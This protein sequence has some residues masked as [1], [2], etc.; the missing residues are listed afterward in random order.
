MKIIIAIMILTSFST[1]A[2]DDLLKPIVD[3]QPIQPIQPISSDL[4][5]R[6]VLNETP[7]TSVL[8]AQK[9]ESISILPATAPIDSNSKIT[10]NVYGLGVNSDQ[11]GR[12]TQYEVIGQPNA[13]TS[14]LE[15]KQDAYGLGVGMDQF[16]RPVKNVPLK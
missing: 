4:P 15:V 12:P 2:D 14:L 13:N 5:P 7:S 1:F 8:S 9:T 11:F 10:P 3:I 6:R 16:G